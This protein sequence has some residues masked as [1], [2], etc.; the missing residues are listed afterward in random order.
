MSAT[1]ATGERVTDD[2]PEGGDD[3]GRDAGADDAVGEARTDPGW[4]ASESTG[5]RLQHETGDRQPREDRQHP[6]DAARGPPPRSERQWDR[7]PLAQAEHRERPPSRERTL[8]SEESERHPEQRHRKAERL[9]RRVLDATEPREHGG[10]IQA[11]T[12]EH[13]HAE[14]GE[15]EREHDQRRERRRRPGEREQDAGHDPSRA[16][17]DACVKASAK[18]RTTPAKLNSSRELASVPR[19][20]PRPSR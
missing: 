3:R 13:R 12:Q 5:R 15:G 10:R 1:P 9:A 19:I 6:H 16:G 14:L 4:N 2:Q 7:Y 11:D 8:E 20:P 18:T 17:H